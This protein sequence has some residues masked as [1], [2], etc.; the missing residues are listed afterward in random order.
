M[1]D[2]VFRDRSG[3]CRTAGTDSHQHHVLL[4]SI[5]IDNLRRTLDNYL[6]RKDRESETDHAIWMSTLYED[7]KLPNEHTSLKVCLRVNNSYNQNFGATESQRVMQ[8]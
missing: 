4:A 5:V 1:V 6:I 7:A 3:W 8:I 2:A